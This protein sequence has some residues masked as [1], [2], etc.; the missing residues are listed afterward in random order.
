MESPHLICTSLA[1]APDRNHWHRG[2]DRIKLGKNSP[3]ERQLTA[4]TSVKL[5]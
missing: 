4:V 2:P 5:V 1:N 3:Y